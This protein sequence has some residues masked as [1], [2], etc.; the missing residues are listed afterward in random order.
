MAS[1]ESNYPKSEA[2]L[3][4]IGLESA[5]KS[6]IVRVLTQ[7]FDMITS[8]KPTQAIERTTIEIIGNK[9][10]LWDFGG[11]NIYRHRYLTK[12]QEYFDNIAF[13]YFVVDIQDQ[14][15]L[16]EAITYYLIVLD[17]LKVYSPTAR[18]ILLFHKSDPSV[19][20]SKEIEALKQRFIEAIGDAMEGS[21]IPIIMY[22]T[23]IYNH[24]SIITAFSQP[25]LDIDNLYK[26]IS[27]LLHTFTDNFNLGFTVLFT[28]NYFELGNWLSDRIEVATRDKLI[29]YLIAHFSPNQLET[30]I[31]THINDPENQDLKMLVGSFGIH[32]GDS[33]MP[34][35][36]VLGFD[37]ETVFEQEELK[38]TLEKMM[39]NIE[40]LL[41]NID[42]FTIETNS[43]I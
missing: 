1:I 32:I 36:L 37:E 3:A 27:T 39:D 30:P 4:I 14:K 7:E 43:V 34:F 24:M 40:K 28:R 16:H 8:L 18:I 29:K 31:I 20:I 12:P 26:S 10:V 33:L 42:L 9:V 38:I 2:K 13:L 5:G 23:S 41:E 35:H 22:Q 25:I 6:S 19:G 21:K 11:Q 15:T 17:H